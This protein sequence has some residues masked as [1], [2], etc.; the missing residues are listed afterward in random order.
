MHPLPTLRS[1]QYSSIV[2]PKVLGKNFLRGS[3]NLAL[4]FGSGGRSRGRDRWRR[5]GSE[6]FGEGDV[7]SGRER[8]CDD[9]VGAKL[10]DLGKRRKR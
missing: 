9:V 7:S 5:E 4:G 1:L 8:I 3:E 10:V 2:R 6:D